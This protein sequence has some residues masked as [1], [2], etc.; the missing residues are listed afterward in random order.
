MKSIKTWALC[1]MLLTSVNSF[2]QCLDTVLE[3]VHT[4]SNIKAGLECWKRMNADLRNELNQVKSSSASMQMEV[5]RLEE[6]LRKAEEESQT[7][8]K[9]IEMLRATNAEQLAKLSIAGSSTEAPPDQSPR[10]TDATDP[11]SFIIQYGQVAEAPSGATITLNTAW[12]GYKPPRAKF[13]LN[14]KY[15]KTTPIGGRI[16]PEGSNASKCY[17][18]LMSVEETPG[19]GPKSARAKLREVCN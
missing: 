5:T 1:A 16:H 11:H 14:G 10:T 6:L 12:P 2:A 3:G 8:K 15:T 18:L 7:Q 4:V 13:I 19:E 9:S 17:F